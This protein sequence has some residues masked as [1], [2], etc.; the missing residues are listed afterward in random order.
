MSFLNYEYLWLLLVLV[1]L[2]IYKNYRDFNIVIYGY[3]FTYIFIVLALCRPVIDAK[4]IE[5]EEVLSD[6]IVAVDLSYSMQA[7][8]IKPNRLIFAKES[9][10]KLLK[11]HQKSRYGVIGFTTNAIVL[12]PLT[13]DSEL[14]KHLYSS[15]DEKLIITRGSSV[16]PALKLARKMSTSKKP[17]LLILSDGADKSSYEEEAKFAKENS[18]VVNVFMIATAFGSTLELDNGELLKDELGDIVVS[19][20]NSAISLIPQMTGGIYTRD[21]D[22]LVDALESQRNRDFK[23]KT[24]IIK[25][26][27]LFYYFV[28]LAIITFL[29]SITTL[30]KY[31]VSILLLFGVTLNADMVMFNEANAHYKAGE[32]EK[33]LVKYEKSK[34]NAIEFK[35]I[36]YYN[37]ANTLV[38]LKEFKKAREAYVKSL[39]LL[40]SKEAEENLYYIMHVKEQK[41]MNTGNQ[42]TDKKSA[43]AKKEE[44]SKKKESAGSSNMKV[45]ANSGVA[46][47][48]S[49]KKTS[50]QSM[51]SI[52]QK[53]A[54]LSSK[55]Y[56]LI[57]KRQVNEK[58]PY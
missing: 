32:Y 20:E 55:Q 7:T 33:A 25:A 41:S 19:R 31:I 28:I 35:S 24:T 26:Q 49:D 10:D 8:D 40:Y 46:D 9:L 45:S 22:D 17:S 53:K 37:L 57:N 50:S 11:A 6:V 34:S 36:I 13:Q 58:N 1:P 47:T 21:F 43:L 39:S 42:K 51:L 27:E 30:K 52:N 12:S 3:I 5:S 29:V 4:P 23:S 48:K 14:L 18:L 15:L 44:S 54:K 56:E 16:M 2:F 38:R